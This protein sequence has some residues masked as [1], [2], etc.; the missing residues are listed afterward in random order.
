ML[1]PLAIVGRL[2]QL[3][4]GRISRL[5]NSRPTVRG[6]RAYAFIRRTLPAQQQTMAELMA[7]KTLTRPL[8]AGPSF[9]PG[10]M[11]DKIPKNLAI[12]RQFKTEFRKTQDINV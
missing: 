9:L 5:D 1:T 8:V 7:N 2:T 10:R 11:A 6:S 4:C 3:T 12:P